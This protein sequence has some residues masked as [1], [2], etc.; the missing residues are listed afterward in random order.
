MKFQS[1][2]FILIQSTVETM[3]TW[4]AHNGS[5]D[6]LASRL[7]IYPPLLCCLASSLLFTPCQFPGGTH[8]SASPHWFPSV[9]WKRIG[10]SCRQQRHVPTACVMKSILSMCISACF[11]FLC[12]LLHLACQLVTPTSPA[13]A[14]S[15]HFNCASTRR[16]TRRAS[17]S[18]AVVSVCI[19]FPFPASGLRWCHAASLQTGQSDG[20]VMA[21]SHPSRRVSNAVKIDRAS[22]PLEDRAD[23]KGLWVCAT[24]YR[25]VITYNKRH[26]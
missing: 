13:V 1:L 12:H 25:F 26:C 22:V 4:R 3:C 17:I 16:V 21:R 10:V 19:I 7:P 5:K 24:C 6:T 8:R 11:L 2:A 14:F 9:L 20:E 18:L 15:S 23:K